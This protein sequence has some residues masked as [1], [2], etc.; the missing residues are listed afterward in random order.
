[1]L[2]R[3]KENQRMHEKKEDVKMKSQKRVSITHI[4]VQTS[5]QR[6]WLNWYSKPVI[7]GNKVEGQGR[8]KCPCRLNF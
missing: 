1:M 6:G 2:T 8:L 7:L 3:R 4:S 5:A